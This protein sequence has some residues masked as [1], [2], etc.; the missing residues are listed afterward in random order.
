MFSKW[1][2]KKSKY[3]IGYN[4]SIHL[5]N[6]VSRYY[7][8]ALKD[9]PIIFEDFLNTVTSSGYAPTSNFFYAINSDILETDNMIVQVLIAVEEEKGNNL[10]EDYRYQTY[11]EVINMLGIRVEG[12]KELDF[13]EAVGVLVEKIVDMNADLASPPFYFVSQIENKTYT[14]ILIKIVEKD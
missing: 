2:K 7:E 14:D 10:P 6:V 5:N 4:Q 8:V 13:S 12:T 1:R 11:Y 9:F 3:D